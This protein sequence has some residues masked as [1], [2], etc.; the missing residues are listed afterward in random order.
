MKKKTYFTDPEGLVPVW[1]GLK[2]RDI[3]LAAGVLEQKFY[4]RIQEAEPQGNKVLPEFSIEEIELLTKQV[5]AA[6]IGANDKKKRKT[7]EKVNRHLEGLGVIIGFFKKRWEKEERER[8]HKAYVKT[9]PNSVYQ[10]HIS[11]NEI[12]PRI[13]RRVQ[14]LGRV[15]LY[16]LHNIIQKSMGWTNSHLHLFTINGVEYE[17]KYDHLEEIEEALDEKRFKLYHVVQE[18]NI[19]FTY[20]YDYGD[21]WEHTVLVEKILPK[22]PEVTYPV[23]IDGRRACPP[24]DCGG[25]YSF[26]EFVEAVRDPNHED[27]QMM[28]DW[29]GYAYDP[30]VFDREAVNRRL[31]KMR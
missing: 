8:E 18:E 30:G 16:K 9:L 7:L 31:R 6:A 26:P 14:V 15:S 11:L 21:D 17:V 29:V 24:E 4:E 12:E 27:H 25:P 19:S 3:V 28:L 5:A 13:W 20:L 10:L 2:D 22:A 1:M 23:C